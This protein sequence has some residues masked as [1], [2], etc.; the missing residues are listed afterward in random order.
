MLSQIFSRVCK[1]W[2]LQTIEILLAFVYIAVTNRAPA[3][4][5]N[6]LLDNL[7]SSTVGRDVAPSMFDTFKAT[8]QR[9]WLKE[10]TRHKAD[11]EHQISVNYYR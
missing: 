10:G 3:L 4:G 8:T 6:L 11:V 5:C 1:L 9:N 2:L 7:S